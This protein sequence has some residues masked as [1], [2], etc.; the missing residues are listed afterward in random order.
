[1][2]VKLLFLL[3][4]GEEI[5]TN[6]SVCLCDRMHLKIGSCRHKSGSYTLVI[7]IS[8]FSGLTNETKESTRT[9]LKISEK[10]ASVSQKNFERPSE[11]PGEPFL[12]TTSKGCKEVWLFGSKI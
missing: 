4:F 2:P 1:M 10:A 11:T 9:E 8:M 7:Y 12:N 6:C 3:P 5:R